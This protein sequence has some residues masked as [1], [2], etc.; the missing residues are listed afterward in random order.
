MGLWYIIAKNGSNHNMDTIF[1]RITKTTKDCFK[2]LCFNWLHKIKQK[3][4]KPLIH[5]Q[6]Y[7][8]TTVSIPRKILDTRYNFW[9]HWSKKPS[10]PQNK[11]ED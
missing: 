3:T 9:Y 5:L 11:N 10:K 2:Q 8:L 7:W 4:D 1:I 6:K